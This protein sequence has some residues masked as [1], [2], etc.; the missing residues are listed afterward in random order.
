M[1]Y[2]FD[3]T[4]KE[5]VAQQRELR[6]ALVQAPVPRPVTCIAGVDVSFNRFERDVYAGVVVLSYPSMAIIERVG[7]R[8]AVD[9]PYVPGLLSYREIPALM[10]AWKRVTSKPDV[11]MVDGHGIAHPRRLG[12]AAHLGLVV[13]LPTIGCAK[14]V[15]YGVYDAPGIERGDAS[16]L[17]DQKTGERIGTVLRTKRNVAPVFVSPGHLATI[18]DAIDIVMACDRGYR[19]PEPTRQAHLFVNECRRGMADPS[20]F[21][22]L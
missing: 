2:R 18:D 14:S 6:H 20:S 22:A 9:F 4:P 7:I 11:V 10:Q 8:T 21:Q 1:Q 19:L 16:A 5:A 17:L 15:L 12:I 3:V 13:G